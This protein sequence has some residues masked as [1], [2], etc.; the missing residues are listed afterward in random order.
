LNI[1]ED[2]IYV[3]SSDNVFN[4]FRENIFII[5]NENNF[6]PILYKN[7]P[8]LSYNSD[9]IMKLLK[10]DK[11]MLSFLHTNE[12][13][14]VG[15]EDLNKYNPNPVQEPITDNKKKETNEKK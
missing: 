11:N 10:V 13:F 4:M 6:E 8:V 15:P 7:T 14:Q 2:K 1:V 12:K 5:F 9:P 3:V